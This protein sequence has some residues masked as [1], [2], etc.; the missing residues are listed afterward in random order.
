MYFFIT[1]VPKFAI[2]EIATRGAIAIMIIGTI[3]AETS[4]AHDISSVLF[5]ATTVLWIINLFIP[6]MLGL[7]FC[8]H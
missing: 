6:A 3:I 2:V 8:P 4:L 1:I 7:F 5:T